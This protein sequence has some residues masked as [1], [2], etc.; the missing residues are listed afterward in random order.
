MILSTCFSS[1]YCFVGL[2][3]YSILCDAPQIYDPV[4]SVVDFFLLF[5]I[6]T[7]SKPLVDFKFKFQV[8]T[9]IT[10]GKKIIYLNKSQICSCISTRLISNPI[11]RGGLIAPR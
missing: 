1:H 4:R 10:S 3:F 7:F 8:L 5:F 2:G 11:L 9:F 6:F